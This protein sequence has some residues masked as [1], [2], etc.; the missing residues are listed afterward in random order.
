M[1]S[2]KVLSINALRQRTDYCC[3]LSIHRLP[4]SGYPL[5][6]RH[7]AF[8]R[9]RPQ[10]LLLMKL[11]N[12]DHENVQHYQIRHHRLRHRCCIQLLC[13]LCTPALLSPLVIG[14]NH[15]YYSIY[16]F[17]GTAAVVPFFICGPARHR[18]R[19]GYQV[20]LHDY[21]PFLHA[22]EFSALLCINSFNLWLVNP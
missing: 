15:T 1:P 2:F 11:K 4:A 13:S 5:V 22:G 16:I 20:E 17:H 12:Y 3:P 10:A 8:K 6:N 9:T 21:P 7:E 19:H 18:L 14:H